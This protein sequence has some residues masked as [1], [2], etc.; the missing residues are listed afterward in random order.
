MAESPTA[1]T[2][3]T[4][5]DTVPQPFVLI[6]V[7]ARHSEQAESG[8]RFLGLVIF[9]NKLKPGTAPAIQ[10]LRQAHLPCRMITGDNALTAVS[11]ARECNLITQTTQ[12][13]AP[14]FVRG[15][16]FM[17]NGVFTDTVR[18]LISLLCWL[19]QGTRLRHSR[20]WNGRAWMT[21]NG[22]WT[23]TA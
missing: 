13:F 15:V 2:V 3:C 19:V 22:S 14:A 5:S 6:Y 23:T 10:A 8:L 4:I 17:T 16:S 9:E 11:V 12:V 1:E 7:V 21:L 18:V 20:N